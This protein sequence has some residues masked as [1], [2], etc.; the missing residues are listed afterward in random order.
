MAL[1][2]GHIETTGSRASAEAERP[3]LRTSQNPV[4]QSLRP[5]EAQNTLL[6]INIVEELSSSVDAEL[7]THETSSAEGER[8]SV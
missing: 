6:T 4:R 3:S 7:G 2:F 8:L 5:M 1:C